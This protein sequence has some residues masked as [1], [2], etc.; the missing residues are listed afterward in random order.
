MEPLILEDIDADEASPPTVDL[1][2]LDPEN[3]DC[4]QIFV[5]ASDCVFALSPGG[6][7]SSIADI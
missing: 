3:R 6:F 7:R 1:S 2:A 4:M 5:D